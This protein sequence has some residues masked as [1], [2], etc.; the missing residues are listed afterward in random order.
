MSGQSH[1]KAK[2]LRLPGESVDKEIDRWIN[3]AT[4]GPFFAAGC[5]GVVAFYEWYGYLTQSPRRPILFT[6]V[7][8]VALLFTGWRFF[9]IRRKVRSLRQG[10]DGERA[11]GQFLE[12]LRADGGQVFHDVPGD[13]FNLDHVVISTHGIYAIET[14]TW[15]KP[16]PNAQVVVDGD[17]LTVAGQV[18]ARNPMIQVTSAAKWLETLLRES[19]G[20]R[21]FVRG[22][23][24]FPGWFVEQRGPTGDVW[25][26][27]PKAL[28]RIYTECADHDCASRCGA[29]CLSFVEICEE[30]GG[31]GGVIDPAYVPDTQVRTACQTNNAF[32]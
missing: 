13:G 14:K 18:P 5:F 2:P 4:L 11:V 32:G 16:W 9:V 12:R 3:D 8:A 24:V 31:E 25:V 29:G 20:K 22:V 17:T 28:P 1:L 15:S 6:A 10:R 23:V 21:F 27:E 26:L 30:R 7:A 19:T